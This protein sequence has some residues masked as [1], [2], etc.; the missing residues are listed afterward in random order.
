MLDAQTTSKVEM[1]KELADLDQ[2]RRKINPFTKER[3]EFNAKL[4]SVKKEKIC[5]KAKKIDVNDLMSTTKW[6][7]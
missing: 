3:C 6:S 1:D 4:I 7:M 5:T 2:E